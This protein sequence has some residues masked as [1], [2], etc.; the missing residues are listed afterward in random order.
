MDAIVFW[1]LDTALI[2]SYLILKKINANIN[3]KDFRIQIVW[4]LIKENLE[5]NEKKPH[6]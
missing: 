6:T 2:N 5:G 3:Q 1:L 4:D